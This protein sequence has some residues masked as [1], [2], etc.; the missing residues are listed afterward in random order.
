MPNRRLLLIGALVFGALVANAT[1]SRAEPE[2]PYG[3][4]SQYA[5]VNIPPW[6]QVSYTFYVNNGNGT[7]TY[8]LTP[9]WDTHE[10]YQQIG[11][12][13]Q[14]DCTTGEIIE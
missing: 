5:I 11:L 13:L 14:M 6:G 2:D 12:W 3:L 10:D 7:A 4:C 1:T 8:R 9:P